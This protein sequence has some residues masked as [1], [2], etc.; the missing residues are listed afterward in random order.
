MLVKIPTL[1]H[2]RG[3]SVHW[4]KLQDLHEKQVSDELGYSGGGSV[5]FR[6]C[7]PPHAK[8]RLLLIHLSYTPSPDPSSTLRLEQSK[9]IIPVL[10][11]PCC[12]S[13]THLKAFNWFS[14]DWLRLS[15]HSISWRPLFFTHLLDSSSE[16]TSSDSSSYLN[17]KSFYK[18]KSES[19]VVQSWLSDPMDCSPPGSSIHEIFQ[20]GILEW[21]AISFSSGSSWPRDWTWVSHIAGRLFTV[22]ATGKSC[23]LS[24]KSSYLFQ[25]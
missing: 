15:H 1:L 24:M 21:V 17:P 16:G 7:L 10:C 5:H 6:P 19:E 22:W 25:S 18:W 2:I 20:A 14:S 3:S 9:S 4:F 11:W 13:L 23:S 8:P 12:L